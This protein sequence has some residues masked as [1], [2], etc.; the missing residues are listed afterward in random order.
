MARIK[1]LAKWYSNSANS[2]EWEENV[3]LMDK[4]M[5]SVGQHLNWQG[6]IA[7]VGLSGTSLNA[8]W[9]KNDVQ[10]QLQMLEDEDYE[11]R[12]REREEEEDEESPLMEES[13]LRNN[14][15]R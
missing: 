4:M 11:Q 14:L 6:S 13:V 2:S 9:E 1:T 15:E 3:T 10:A 7:E 5:S 8:L 12:E